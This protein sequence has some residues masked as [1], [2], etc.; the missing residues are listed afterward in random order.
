MEMDEIIILILI[1]TYYYD[2]TLRSLC[3]GLL[4]ILRSEDVD[5]ERPAA[6]GVHKILAAPV[7]MGSLIA[8]EKKE[9][10]DSIWIQKVDDNLVR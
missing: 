10:A 8:P 6:N 9:E 2:S 3:S 5:G 1:T 4:G 7:H